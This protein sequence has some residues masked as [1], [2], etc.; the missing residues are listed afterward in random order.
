MEKKIL[1][2]NSIDRDINSY[3]N[4]GKFSIRLDEKFKNI[5]SIRL[6]SIELPN[7]NNYYT[8]NKNFNNLSFTI[9]L[10][11]IPNINDILLLPPIVIEPGN[12]DNN[13]IISVINTKFATINTIHTQHF[14]ISLD[15]INNTIKIHNRQ[16]FSINFDNNVHK[17]TLGYSLGFRK[18]SYN[19]SN[20]FIDSILSVNSG[21]TTY[22]WN[23]DTIIDLTKNSYIYVKINDYG[24]I[25]DN[26]IKNNLLAKIITNDQKTVID[27]GANFLTKEFIF[28]QPVNINKLEIE[29]LN[30]D[31]STIDTNFLDYSLTIELLQI[32]DSNKFTNNNFNVY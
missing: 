32:Y 8:F 24:I 22:S 5:S 9:T 13:S 31:G 4:P 15:T 10:H 16:P 14:E 3:P 29:L 18:T 2:I 11:N 12:Y 27:N 28:K 21:F 20:Q 17:K 23:S 1:S 19:Y 26:N 6:A 7:L 30:C 25:Y